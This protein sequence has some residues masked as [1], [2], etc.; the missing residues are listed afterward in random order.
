MNEQTLLNQ[1]DDLPQ[2]DPN[3]DYYAELVG[4]NKKFKDNQSLAKSKFES[5]QYV[6]IL[7]KRMDDLREDYLTVRKENT[8]RARLEDLVDQIAKNRTSSDNTPA[9]DD[10][11]NQPP[12]VDP[13]QIKSLISEEYRTIRQQEREVDNWNMVKDKLQQRYGKNYGE[14]VKQQIEDLGLTE[15]DLNAMARRQPKVLIKTLGLDREQPRQD[16]FQS[17]PRSEQRRDTFAPTGAPVR[18]WS[19]YQNLKKTD[20]NIY[21]DRKTAIQMQQDAIE[22]G[23]KFRDGDYFVKGLHEN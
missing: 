18:S 15:Q 19:Y 1:E 12:T 23:E 17:F 9:N 14:A 8:T 11:K 7:E 2:S 6:K 10:N 16:T 4:E 13:T 22:L 5:D 20:P 21:Y 3:K